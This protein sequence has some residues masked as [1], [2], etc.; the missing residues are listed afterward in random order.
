[1]T[2]RA[3]VGGAGSGLGRAS[4][5]ALAAAGADLLLWSR[6]QQA[7]DEVADDLRARHGGTVHVVTADATDPAAAQT[8]ASAA[9]ELLG[10]V[11]ICVLNAGGPPPCPPDQTD[12]A[13]WQRS[14]QLLA[15]TPIDL[16]TRLLP[17]MRERGF[18]RVVAVL[19][20][21]VREPLPELCYSNS[22][23]AALTAWLKTVAGVVAADGVT[24]NG[25]L[26]GRIATPRVAS[27]DSGRAKRLGTTAEEVRA[28]SQASIPAHRYGT[29]EEF[30][31]VV[32][33]LASDA[34]SYV[35]GSFLS[36]DG[37]MA[38]STL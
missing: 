12:P 35:T 1:V 19:S 30:A 36:C 7:L 8:V 28:Q 25:V 21:G 10:G 22:G 20:S 6:G 5:D 9:E 38:R 23:R 17:G 16:A 34:A 15:T 37:G 27:L 33:F 4:A 32:G 24:V 11:D 14:F 29:P 31:A 2:R 13:E 3:V 26:P 18:G